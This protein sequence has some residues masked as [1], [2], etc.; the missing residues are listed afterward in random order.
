MSDLRRF[1]IAQ[2]RDTLLQVAAVAKRAELDARDAARNIATESEKKEDGRVA[3][4]FGSLAT[5]HQARSREA[6]EQVQALDA[7]LARLPVF[8]PA[9][10]VGLGAIVDV[11][12]EDAHGPS[13]RTFIV[14]PVGA[15]TELSGPGGDGFVTVI[16]PASPVGRALMGR[17]AG[18]V[19]DVTLRGE[20]YEWEILTV[21]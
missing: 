12:T 7:L 20:P 16:T 5:G 11:A 3:L 1:F 10:A 18:A 14:L 9:S 8:G 6:Q 19:V 21:G 17:P 4:E 2:L 13:E 15:G